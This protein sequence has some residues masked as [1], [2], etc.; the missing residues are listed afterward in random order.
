[1]PDERR[2]FSDAAFDRDGADSPGGQVGC[3]DEPTQKLYPRR[4]TRRAGEMPKLEIM[5]IAL[6][7]LVAFILGALAAVELLFNY[8]LW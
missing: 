6:I 2:P 4:P 1:M 3:L 5:L 8:H 7:L